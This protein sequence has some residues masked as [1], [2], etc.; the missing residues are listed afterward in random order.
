MASPYFY[1][2]ISD[3]LMHFKHIQELIDH[4][5][6]SLPIKISTHTVAT[7][8]TERRFNKWFV[9][10]ENSVELDTADYWFL[11]EPMIYIK[12]CDGRIPTIKIEVVDDTYND[13]FVDDTIEEI[14]S[15]LIHIDERYK[16]KKIN[17]EI[18]FNL[19]MLCCNEF[20]NEII[21]KK[22]ILLKKVFDDLK[23][24]KQYCGDDDYN[25]Q[26][27]KILLEEI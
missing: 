7:L 24:L 27:Q 9:V 20:W 14:N 26:L 12:I 21:N 2:N 11:D 3:N 16:I 19:V 22:D 15:E 25:I 17:N 13:D 1:R 23:L 18:I 6:Y 4:F 10:P 5:N 8:I